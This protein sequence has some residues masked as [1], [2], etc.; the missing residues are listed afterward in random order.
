[1]TRDLTPDDLDDYVEKSEALMDK[2]N[3]ILDG[4]EAH[5]CVSALIKLA[6][7]PFILEDNRPLWDKVTDS[8]FKSM[9]IEMDVLCDPE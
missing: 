2:L 9:R 8:A 7:L 3:V 4:H 5:T 1:M 6:V